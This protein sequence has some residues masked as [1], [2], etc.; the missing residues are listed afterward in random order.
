M[1]FV[2]VSART[3]AVLATA[4]AL[5][6]SPLT[7]RADVEAVR[8][9]RTGDAYPGRPGDVVLDQAD[10]SFDPSTPDLAGVF[11]LTLART[12]GDDLL[13]HD[14]NTRITSPLMQAGAI[15]LEGYAIDDFGFGPVIR[16]TSGVTL[17]GGIVRDIPTG[18]TS[19]AMLFVTPAGTARTII[20]RN[21]PVPSQPGASYIDNYLFSSSLGAIGYNLNDNGRVA[22]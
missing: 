1:W 19:P 13:V 17:T 4:A 7:T 22:L 9:I 15:T 18:L 16:N 10:A 14:R 8:I 2:Q 12:G 5:F 21:R 20:A 3:M 11:S 6:S